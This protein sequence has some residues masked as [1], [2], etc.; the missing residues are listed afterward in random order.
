MP[1][2]QTTTPETEPNTMRTLVHLSDLHFGR[3]DPELLDPLRDLVHRIAP[4]VVVISGDLTQRAK[5]EEFEAAKAWIDTLPGPQIIV[6]G[7]HDISLYNVFRRFALPLQRY[8]RYITEDLDPVYI[9]EEI[10]VLGVNTARSL[11]FKDGR[12]NKEQVAKIRETL[13]KLDPSI[14]R[15]VVTHHPFDLPEGRKEDELIDRAQMAMEA[16]AECGVDLL[17]AGHLHQSHAGNTQARYKISEFAAL[18]V[19]AGTATSTRGR[20][21][22]NSFNVIRTEADKIEVDRYGWDAV[23][24]QFQVLAT[25]KFLRSGNI[26]TEVNDGLYAAGI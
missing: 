5:S 26:W 1:E 6:P 2:N 15:V 4:T 24:K 8:K 7:N 12:V 13:D 3:V 25:E 16:F 20:G 10:A 9:D 21:E 18:V 22:V 17:M 14:T 23:H 19:Q 11:T